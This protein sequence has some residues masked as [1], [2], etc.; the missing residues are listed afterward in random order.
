MIENKVYEF[1]KEFCKELNIPMNQAERRLNELLEWL[2]NYFDY[3]FYK[4]HPNRILIK[5]IM[6]E[7]QPMPRKLPKQDALNEAKRQDYTQFTIASLGPECK[8]NSKSKI[9]RDAIDAFGREKYS[10]T[11]SEAVCK[12]YIKEPF[13]KYGETDDK[14]VWVYY[15]TYEPLDDDVLE[16][17]RNILRDENIG[18]QEAANAFYRMNEGEDVSKEIGYYNKARLRFK[19]KYKDIPILVKSWKLNSAALFLK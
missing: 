3:E 16:V 19:E 15:S 13:D 10:H 11:N 8:P 17:W 14:T 2:K 5:E 18:E 9:A 6:G 7:Y 1:K 4:G 12:R